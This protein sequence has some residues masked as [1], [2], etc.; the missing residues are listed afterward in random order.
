[1]TGRVT[2]K[3]NV[4]SFGV[5]LMELI[6]VR[7]A[8]NE[9]DD[10]DP[11]NIVYLVT[12]FRTVHI[13]QDTFRMAVDETIELDNGTLASVRKVAELAEQCC[14]S[15]PYRRPDMAR[16]VNVLSSLAELWKPCH[17]QIFCHLQIQN[18]VKLAKIV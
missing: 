13:N 4:F 11:E 2:T 17:L 10:S 15:E 18:F 16:V 1:M 14:A 6:T 9:S 8:I 5:I 12:W 7:K 3:V